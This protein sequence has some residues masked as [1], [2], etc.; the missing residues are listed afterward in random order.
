MNQNSSQD[1]NQF[2]GWL[3][4]WYWCLIIG[5]A[6]TILGMVLPALIGIAGAFLVGI[7]YLLGSLVSIAATVCA[8][9]MFIQAALQLKARNPKFFDTY[10]LGLFISVGGSIVSNLL[11]IRSVGGV[12]SFIGTLIASVIGLAIGLVLS[13]MYFSKSKRVAVYFNGRPL[14]QSKYWGWINLLPGTIT[15]DAMPD[16]SQ[17]QQQANAQQAAPQQAAP[18]Q[19]PVQQPPV[20]EPAPSQ[21]PPAQQ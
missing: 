3:M 17:F 12:G 15:S 20:Q 13:I 5:N 4:V 14:Q 9:I 19:A 7:V 21:E 8:A 2:G 11:S 18:Q 6:F 1:Y 16:P 10:L